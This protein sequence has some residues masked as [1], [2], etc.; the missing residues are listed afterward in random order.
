MMKI[1][2]YHELEESEIAK[3][4]Y[5]LIALLFLLFLVLLLSVKIEYAIPLNLVKES[6][7]V[8]QTYITE[9]KLNKI[10][11][12][13]ILKINA[14]RYHYKLEKANNQI[15]LFDNLY[16]LVNFKIKEKIE[17]DNVLVKV[18]ISSSTLFEK[19]L[20]FWKEET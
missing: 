9:S 8:Y 1:N 3:W 19:I 20:K 5:V 13:G 10:K 11:E 17:E 16:Y 7:Q 2:N 14:K 6:N 4:K 18:E 15:S 12:K